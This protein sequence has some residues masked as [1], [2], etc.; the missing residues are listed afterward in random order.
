M[1]AI[2]S[3]LELSATKKGIRNWICSHPLLVYGLLA[4]GV[5]WVLLAMAWLTIQTGILSPDSTLIG[6]LNQ[7]AA[8]SPALAASVVIAST[9]GW[10]GIKVWLRRLIQ[11][12]VGIHWYLL[13]LL[14]LPLVMLA[15]MS[16]I[17]KSLPFDSLIQNWQIL[18]THYLPAVIMTALTTG[19][20]EEPGWRGFAL[21]HLQHKYGPLIGNLILGLFWSFWHLPNVLFEL[22]GLTIGLT[23]FAL[24]ILPTMVNGFMLAWVFNSTRGSLLLVILLHATQNVSGRLIANLVGAT[25]RLLYINQYYVVSFLAF[26]IALLVIIL[27]TRGRFGYQPEPDLA[28]RLVSADELA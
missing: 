27:F 16:F 18:F 12:H 19:L 6:L 13:V 1:T 11:W 15:G 22:A 7:I 21:Q 23:T 28:K 17:Y 24:F 10:I 25:D 4:Y 5:S 14:G 20:A 8:F 9:G 3:T 2:T 26:G